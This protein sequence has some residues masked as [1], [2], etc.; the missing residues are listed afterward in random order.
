VASSSSFFSSDSCPCWRYSRDRVSSKDRG[1]FLS[2]ESRPR[3]ANT[4]KCRG[5]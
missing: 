5:Y 2:L 4:W 1:V 3:L